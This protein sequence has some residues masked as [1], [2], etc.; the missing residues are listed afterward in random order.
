MSAHLAEYLGMNLTALRAVITI[1]NDG[2]ILE[3][4]IRVMGTK[5]EL[6]VALAE[7]DA[8]PVRASAVLD[9]PAGLDDDERRAY[10]RGYSESCTRF[11]RKHGTPSLHLD[12][13]SNRIRGG[14]P[15]L[16]QVT[17]E[18]EWARHP[19]AH[20]AGMLA[21]KK[22]RAAEGARLLLERRTKRVAA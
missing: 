16:H 17:V 15:S 21:V 11:A 12:D 8:T 13:I 5:V 4:R 14:A 19:A 6:A 20:R 22:Y 9:M 18:Y 7:D 2:R 1:R 10:V 3:H